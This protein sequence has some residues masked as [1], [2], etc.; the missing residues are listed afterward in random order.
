MSNRVGR[1]DLRRFLDELDFVRL[2]GRLESQRLH[3][4][5]ELLEDHERLGILV[6]RGT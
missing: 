2:N 6:R 1:L 3:I 5:V 4:V